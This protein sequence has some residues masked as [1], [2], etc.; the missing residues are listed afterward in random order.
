MAFG[1]NYLCEV[2]HPDLVRVVSVGVWLEKCG[3]SPRCICNISLRLVA[4]KKKAILSF[5]WFTEGISISNFPIHIESILGRANRDVWL[6]RQRELH[7]VVV[8][9][10]DD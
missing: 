7:Y 8:I 6:H 1:A 4:T 3:N 5:S 9:W 2:G 10:A